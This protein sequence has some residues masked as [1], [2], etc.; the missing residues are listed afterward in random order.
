MTTLKQWLE[1]H[2]CHDIK[3]CIVT[4]GKSIY[5]NACEYEQDSTDPNG[6]PYTIHCIYVEGSLHRAKDHMHYSW[7]GSPAKFWFLGGYYQQD[8][9]QFNQYHFSDS[10]F[11]SFPWHHNDDC[12]VKGKPGKMTVEYL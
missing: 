6:K 12:G 11:Q 2:N 5:K 8:N 1:S 7:Q 3:P 4:L 9:P 10:V